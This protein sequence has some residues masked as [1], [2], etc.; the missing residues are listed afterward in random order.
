[1]KEKL[2]QIRTALQPYRAILLFVVALLGAHFFWKW[3]VIADEQG[4]PVFWFG[5]D[6]TAPFDYLSHQIS[7]LAYLI[8]SLWS[9]TVEFVEPY[10]LRFATGTG[11]K[12]VW[13]CTGLKQAFIWLVIML[14]APGLWKRKSWFIPLGWA[15]IYV[16]NLLRVVL[17]AISVEHHPEWFDFLHAYVFKY[18]FYFMLFL[19]WV[20]WTEKL[21]P[22]D[23]ETQKS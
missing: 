22:T 18:L 11:V 17:I 5:L 10:S 9:D 21:V 14:C 6:I 1:M 7:H 8:I 13:S 20:W 19:L 2:Q 16:F 15:C 3:T 4:G 23:K 12:I